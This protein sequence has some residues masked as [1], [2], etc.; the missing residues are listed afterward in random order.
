VGREKVLLQREQKKGERAIY[1]HTELGG[2]R[3]KRS[4]LK[5]RKKEEGRP[6]GVIVRGEGG[7]KK[8]KKTIG[9]GGKV[10]KILLPKA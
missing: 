2:R 1:L 8:E 6:S 10:E 7:R 4:L 3:E 9:G 5:L